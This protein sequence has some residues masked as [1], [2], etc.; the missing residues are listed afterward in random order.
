MF[1]D[2][3]AQMH[4]VSCVSCFVRAVFCYNL[5]H[6]HIDLWATYVVLISRQWM[7][8][9]STETTRAGLRDLSRGRTLS[10][11]VHYRRR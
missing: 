5:L 10:V 7:Q 1:A 11:S 3:R 6:E 8:S 9:Q 4:V 2:V